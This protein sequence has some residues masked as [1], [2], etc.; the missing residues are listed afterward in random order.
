LSAPAVISPKGPGYS[1]S[2]PRK[3]ASQVSQPPLQPSMHLVQIPDIGTTFL[4]RLNVPVASL[5]LGLLRFILDTSDDK[6]ANC[7]AYFIKKIKFE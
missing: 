2:L 1:T 4:D 7:V 5:A 6:Y 3:E